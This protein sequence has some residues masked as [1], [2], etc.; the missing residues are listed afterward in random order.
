MTMPVDDLRAIQPVDDLE[1]HWFAFGEAE[2]FSRIL[3][4]AGSGANLLLR[5][6]LP[7]NLRDLDAVVRTLDVPS[8]NWWS[9][10]SGLCPRKERLRFS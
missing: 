8:R 5:C 9:R 6:K 2:E 4:T 1:G 10:C 7:L 3:A